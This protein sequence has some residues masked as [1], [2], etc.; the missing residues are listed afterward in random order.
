[1]S[2]SFLYFDVPKLC[3][4]AG[5]RAA[6]LIPSRFL[7]SDEATHRFGSLADLY[8]Q[9]LSRSDPFPGLYPTDSTTV[10]DGFSGGRKDEKA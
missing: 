2:A 9:S 8:A 1:M 10:F 7:N 4:V 5:G 3:G 6:E